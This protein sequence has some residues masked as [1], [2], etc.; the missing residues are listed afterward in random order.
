MSVTRRQLLS[1]AGGALVG[2]VVLPRGAG[3][4]AAPSRVAAA[5]PVESFHSRPTLQPPTL[6]IA[7]RPEARSSNYLFLA[8]FTGPGQHGPLIVDDR[9][10]VVWFHPLQNA[11]ATTFRAQRYRGKPVLTWWEGQI[12]NTGVGTGIGVIYDSSYRQVA[13]VRAGNGYSADLHELLLT[14]QGTALICAYNPV[15]TDLSSVG[16]PAAGTA[17]DSIVQEVDV[18]S[19]RVLFEWHSL[20]HVALAD[21]FIPPTAAP[22]D[23]FHV[24]SIDVDADG[25]LLI[26]ARNTCA[27]YTIDRKTGDVVWRLGGKRSDFDVSPSSTFMFQHDARAHP[28]GSITLFDDGPSSASQVSRAI[29][30]G[31][32]RSELR[33]VLQGEYRHPEPHVAIAMGSAQV[34]ADDSVLVGWGTVPSVTQFAPNGSVRFDANFTGQA[35]NYRALRFPWVGRPTSKPALKVLSSRASTTVYVSWNGSTETAY[36]RIEAGDS[37]GAVRPVRT[38][39]ASGFETA[40]KIP[41]RPAFLAAT[42]L[43]RRRTRLGGSGP[44]AVRKLR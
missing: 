21:S 44:V 13:Q 34:L 36:W 27:L 8:P 15:P 5:D 25:N 35:W 26:S 30:L 31:V 42:A 18:A 12:S 6:A 43:D 33:A 20:Q 11:S 32:D 19:G 17:L 3:A 28:D 7:K 22:Y 39:A 4:Q 2:A 10:E 14:P 37:R 16:G 41:G 38:V 24:N 40:V 9:G 1:T 23:Y 29:R